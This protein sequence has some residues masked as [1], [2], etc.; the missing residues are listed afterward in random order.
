MRIDERR[1]SQGKATLWRTLRGKGPKVPPPVET[2]SDVSVEGGVSVDDSIRKDPQIMGAE[3][4][5][6]NL[7][8]WI[9]SQ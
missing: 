6:Q 4:D 7:M 5:I 8:L 9:E 1:V 3:R 2:P